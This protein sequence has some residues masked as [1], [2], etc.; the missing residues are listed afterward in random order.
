MADERMIKEIKLILNGQE[1]SISI[2]EAKK[3][4]YA[5]SELFGVPATTIKEYVPYPLNPYPYY[6]HWPCWPWTAGTTWCGSTGVAY[7]YNAGTV[8]IKL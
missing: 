4:H 8:S 1:I 7:D 3:L 6:P 2:D 5:L